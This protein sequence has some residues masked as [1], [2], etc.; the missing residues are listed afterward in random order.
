MPFYYVDDPCRRVHEEANN[1]VFRAGV[2]C[3][4]VTDPAPKTGAECD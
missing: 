4:A 3:C 2:E 1:S